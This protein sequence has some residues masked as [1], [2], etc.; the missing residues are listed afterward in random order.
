MRPN[1]FSHLDAFP[2]LGTGKLDLR[3]AA[4]SGGRTQRSGRLRG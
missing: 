3:K 1:R 4:G 2:C